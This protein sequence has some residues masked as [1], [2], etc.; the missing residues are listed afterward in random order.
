VNKNSLKDSPNNIKKPVE[1]IEEC[2]S[3]STDNYLKNAQ[4]KVPECS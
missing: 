1:N 4:D 3:M 2:E